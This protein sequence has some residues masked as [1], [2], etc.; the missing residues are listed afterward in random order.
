MPA[1]LRYSALFARPWKIANSPL[2]GVNP[3]NKA[4]AINELAKR[5]GYDL[6]HSYAYSDSL[7]D[8]P[9]LE[10]VGMPHAVNPDSGL[11][12]ISIE[13]GW[14]VLTFEKPASSTVPGCQSLTGQKTVSPTVP[15]RQSPTFQNQPAQLHQDVKA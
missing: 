6:S 15:G 7:T 14:P 4:I 9:M 10:A 13:R 2:P 5:E 1:S 3:Q 8:L 11:R 12:E